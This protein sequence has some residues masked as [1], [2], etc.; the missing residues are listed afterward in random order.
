MVK[1]EFIWL[2]D[3]KLFLVFQSVFGGIKNYFSAPPKPLKTVREQKD[4]DS[5]K[6]NGESKLSEVLQNSSSSSNLSSQSAPTKTQTTLPRDRS[7]DDILDENLGIMG[8]SL[9]R[10]KGLG[11]SLQTEIEDQNSMVE[12][13]IGKVDNS[14]HRIQQ[15]N[16]QMNKILKK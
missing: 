12:R 15:Q 8:A 13:I 16:Q 11:L 3:V 1:N 9:S 6:S 10:L 2:I 14:D 5:T 4:D 7:T